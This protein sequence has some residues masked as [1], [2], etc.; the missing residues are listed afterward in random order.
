MK[1]VFYNLIAVLVG[2][3]VLSACG[4]PAS[5]SV[6]RLV[7]SPATRDI[8]INIAACFTAD[9]GGAGVYAWG[10]DVPTSYFS[11]TENSLCFVPTALGPYNLV[12][13]WN[14]Q[15]ASASGVVIKP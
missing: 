13:K 1:R 9:G 5:P 3:L 10:L 7:I 6:S 14:S 2:A 11:A 8:H 4:N 15:T 12:V